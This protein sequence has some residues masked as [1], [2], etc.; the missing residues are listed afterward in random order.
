MAAFAMAIFLQGMTSS[1]TAALTQVMLDS[2]DQ[3][4][5]PDDPLLAFRCQCCLDE[6]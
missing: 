3:L 6:G 1:E 2:G 4:H 5:W